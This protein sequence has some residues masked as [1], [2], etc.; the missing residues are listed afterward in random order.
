M[1]DYEQAN[2]I[3]LMLIFWRAGPVILELNLTGLFILHVSHRGTAEAGR[4]PNVCVL[5]V[6]MKLAG[7]L[8]QMYYHCSCPSIECVKCLE[9]QSCSLKPDT[10]SPSRL[11]F[12]SAAFFD[13]AWGS[14]RSCLVIFGL[15][16]PYVSCVLSKT[17]N[18]QWRKQREGSLCVC[19]A[20]Y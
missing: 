15:W 6:C 14:T 11:R 5:C 17:H 8:K 4:L 18:G 10:L 1:D 12:S 19:F 13:K 9:L 16:G 7:Q 20:S 2:I 3:M